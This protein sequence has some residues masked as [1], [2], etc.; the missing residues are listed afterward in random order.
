MAD[1]INQVLIDDNKRDQDEINKASKAIS[2]FE[3][4]IRIKR[5]KQSELSMQIKDLSKILE[6]KK[7]KMDNLETEISF[8][9]KNI[10]EKKQLI[11]RKKC[12]I[13]FRSLIYGKILDDSNIK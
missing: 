13:H 11:E 12:S 4:A 6:E 1:L 9:I 5:Y 2:N 3:E 7:A 8:L 10:G